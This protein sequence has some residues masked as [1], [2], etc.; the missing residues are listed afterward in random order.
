MKKVK[1]IF[2]YLLAVLPAFYTAIAVFFFLPDTVAAHFGVNGMPNRYG[3]KYE[4]FIL[5]AIILG[6]AALYFFIR[7]FMERSSFDDNRKTARNLDVLDTAI[8]LIFVLLNV[9]CVVVMILMA[10]PSEIQKSDSL[11][12][13]ILSVAVGLMFILL[14]NILPKTRRNSFIGMRMK[15]CMDTNEHWYI[16]NRAGGIAMVLAGLCTI[17]AGLI[18]RNS[19]CVFIMLISLA[20]FLTVAIIWSYVKIKGETTDKR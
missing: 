7:K 10:H 11:L 19:V 13:L 4:A 8:L 1:I 5:P 12:F 14:G 20:L 3:S 6:V 17:I 9:L 2:I 18:F 15:F 16:A